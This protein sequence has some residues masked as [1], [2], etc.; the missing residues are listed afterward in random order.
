MTAGAV[1]G[2]YLTFLVG[3]R[4]YGLP[5]LKVKEILEVGEITPLPGLPR[6][7]R[8]VINIRGKVMPVVDVAL[9]FGGVETSLKGRACIIVMEVQQG[10]HLV[11]VGF[12][13]EAVR[14]VADIA[15]EAIEPA[16]S[17]GG[18]DSVQALEGVAKV[19]ER[20]VVL[21]RGDALLRGNNLAALAGFDVSLQE[22][23]GLEQVA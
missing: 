18:E 12:I 8:G 19:G 5:I 16:P 4:L 3:G 15:Q 9:L 2:K 7:H 21:L 6:A 11:E 10:D 14:E 23:A 17:F 20:L 1:A 13:V 22:P